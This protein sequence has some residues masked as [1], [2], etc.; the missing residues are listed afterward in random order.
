MKKLLLLFA[1]LLFPIPAFAVGNYDCRVEGSIEEIAGGKNR[2]QTAISYTSDEAQDNIPFQFF[3]QTESGVLGSYS[4][5]VDLDYTGESVNPFE[6][7]EIN[8]NVAGPLVEGNAIITKEFSISGSSAVQISAKLN[9]INCTPLVLETVEQLDC[10]TDGALTLLDLGEN[11]LQYSLMY[12]VFFDRDEVPFSIEV[13]NNE[14]QFDTKSG[15]TPLYKDARLAILDRGM[16]VGR[17]TIPEVFDGDLFVR[18]TLGGKTCESTTLTLLELLPEEVEPE[19]VVEEEIPVLILEEQNEQ[20]EQSDIIVE[21]ETTEV[22]TTDIV[23]EDTVIAPSCYVVAKG[24][25]QQN[26]EVLI[27]TGVMFQ[28]FETGEHNYRFVG[29]PENELTDQIQFMGQT[30]FVAENG[31][32][33][34]STRQASFPMVFTPQSVDDT[35]VVNAMIDDIVCKSALF[36]GAFI[37]NEGEEVQNT[38]VLPLGITQ[39]EIP[40]IETLELIKVEEVERIDNISEKEISASEGEMV[41]TTN[42]MLFVIILIFASIIVGGGIVFV[43]RK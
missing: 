23:V 32:L 20:Q 36:S 33:I 21:V 42:Q 30:D 11:E 41:V 24:Q 9:G 27:G 40:R 39:S 2:L 17:V 19:V 10:N 28:H 6:R 34:D 12:D 8:R 5:E 4:G 31:V 22:D 1:L 25:I 29:Y 38:Q 16:A 7:S 3:M 37:D 35:Y 13:Y 43:I 15:T 26:G 18:A 14:G